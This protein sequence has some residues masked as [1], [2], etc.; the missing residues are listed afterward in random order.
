[1]YIK[2]Q[3]Q[4]LNLVGSSTQQTH[5]SQ[6]G[7][8]LQLMQVETSVGQVPTRLEAGTLIEP[9]YGDQ[10]FKPCYQGTNQTGMT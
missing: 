1:M 5:K 10:Y 7:K 2:S 6:K 8:H 9:C 3:V 4:D